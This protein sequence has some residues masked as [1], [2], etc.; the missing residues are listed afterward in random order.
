MTDNYPRGASIQGKIF[1]KGYY[2]NHLPI[3]ISY[4]TA[5]DHQLLSKLRS[6]VSG[7][8]VVIQY[9]KKNRLFYG[10]PRDMTTVDQG[11]L[12]ESSKNIGLCSLT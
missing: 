10:P 6:R 2:F 7:S 12:L 9:S 1:K 8:L 5:I 11:T 4:L 3:S